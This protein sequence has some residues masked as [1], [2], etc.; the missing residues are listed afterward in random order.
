[1][2]LLPHPSGGRLIRI[3]IVDPDDLTPTTD[4][5]VGDFDLD[6]V[7]IDGAD[8]TGITGE[9][10][11]NTAVVRQLDLA[12]AKLGPLTLVDTVLSGADL[13]NA[14]LQ[15]VTARR[16]E[17]RTCRGIGLRLSIEHA[18]DLAVTD[19]RLDYATL[20]I[21]RVKGIAVF[22]GCSF[23][24]TT[25]SGDLSD[26]LF[27]DCDFTDTEFRASRATRCDLRTSRISS[28]RGLLSLRGAMISP[29][30]TISIATLIAAE[31]GLI[32]AD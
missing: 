30:Q 27:L 23:R 14:S 19:C 25:I 15:R 4:A 11:F 16:S 5:L 24:E 1:V 21:E 6:S 26:V 18:A 20:H 3:P 8:A 32:V 31:A 7:L 2:T 28:A 10:A 17:L 9:G 29:D 13:S 22:T 12:G